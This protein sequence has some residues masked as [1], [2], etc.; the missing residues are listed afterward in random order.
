MASLLQQIETNSNLPLMLKILGITFFAVSF[1]ASWSH[2]PFF[3]RLGMIVGILA[4][5]V[6]LK[7]VKVY[8]PTPAS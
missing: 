6:G 8:S 3:Y 5:I 2:I 1:I 4:F 7:F